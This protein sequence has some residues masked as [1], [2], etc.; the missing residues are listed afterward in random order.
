MIVM[1][2]KSPQK[3]DKE[4]S[5]LFSLFNNKNNLLNWIKT[6]FFTYFKQENKVVWA[7]CSKLV[8]GACVSDVRFM[9]SYRPIKNRQAQEDLIKCWPLMTVNVIITFYK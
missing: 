7:L 4:K 3:K 6:F 2:A 9:N 5:A 1:I 8:A